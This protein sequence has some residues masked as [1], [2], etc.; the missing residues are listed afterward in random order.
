MVS[1]LT[2]GQNNTYSLLVAGDVDLSKYDMSRQVEKHVCLKL[3]DGERLRQEFIAYNKAMY[4]CYTSPDNFI[5]PVAEAFKK[6]ITELEEST[7]E[8]V[9]WEETYE[10]EHDPVT[11]DA[12]TT[13]NPDGK[14]RKLLEP[15]PTTTMY[16]YEYVDGEGNVT[17]GSFEARKAEVVEY[18]PDEKDVATLSRI[19][20]IKVNGATPETE[21]EKAFAKN[22]KS[23][24]QQFLNTYGTKDRYVKTLL[25]GLT[26]NAFVSEE[27]GW[28]EQCDETDQIQWMI[29]FYDRFIK[30]LP[31]NTQLK[32]YNF[33]R[34]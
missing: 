11:G 14:W 9:F 27:T 12:L 1:R 6:R 20:D 32:V 26:Y 25:S 22:S 3:S 4:D 5:K 13:A 34:E 21:N 18:T 30:D 2:N 29:D 24:R 10:L 23:S 28:I 31:H 17:G 15:D 33:T 19:W 8:D 16:L 7:G